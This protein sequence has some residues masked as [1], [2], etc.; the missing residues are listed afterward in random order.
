MRFPVQDK[1]FASAKERKRIRRKKMEKR[2][3]CLPTRKDRNMTEH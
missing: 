2:N 1:N 3:K